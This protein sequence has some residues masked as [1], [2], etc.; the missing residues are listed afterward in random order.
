MLNPDSVVKFDTKV[1]ILI[2]KAKNLELRV[3]GTV[4]PPCV[5]IDLVN[6]LTFKIFDIIYF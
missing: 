1:N 3:C 5:D 6:V 2:R 4:E